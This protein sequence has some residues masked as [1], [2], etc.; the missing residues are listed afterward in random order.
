MIEQNV[1]DDRPRKVVA[2]FELAAPR[3][4]DEWLAAGT[5]HV[6]AAEMCIAQEFLEQAGLTV[7][8]TIGARVRIVNRQGRAEEISRED[9]VMMALRRLAMQT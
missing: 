4:V 3:M 2:R 8:R 9:A 1:L 6:S 5:M 7:E